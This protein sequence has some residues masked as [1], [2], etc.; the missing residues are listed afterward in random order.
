MKKGD[1]VIIQDSSYSRIIMDGK[2]ENGQYENVRYRR[3]VIIEVGCNFPQ[4]SPWSDVKNNNTIVQDCKTAEVIFILE[5][6]LKL[7]KHTI[8]IDGKTIELS[9]ESFLNIKEQLA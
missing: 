6:F 2:L 7:E 9:H 3:C 5:R 4:T 8:V 1:V